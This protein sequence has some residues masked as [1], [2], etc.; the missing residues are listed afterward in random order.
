VAYKK[1]KWKFR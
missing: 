1:T